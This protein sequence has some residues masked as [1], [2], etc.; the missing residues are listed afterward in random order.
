M[1]SIDNISVGRCDMSNVGS[2]FIVDDDES[3]LLSVKAVLSQFGYQPHCF[4]SADA[5]LAQATLDAP[6][7]VITDL[8]MPGLN[9]LQLQERLA[10]ANSMLSVIVLTGVAD[11]PTAVKV[12]RN[13][14]AMLLEKP[15]ASRDLLVSV[16]QGIEASTK[17]WRSWQVEQ[18]VRARLESLTEDEHAVMKLMLSGAPNKSIA[19]TMDL[20]MRTVDRRRQAIFSKMGVNTVA[21]L[22]MK[23]SAGNTGYF[24]QPG[25]P[26]AE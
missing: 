4:T 24:L 10:A 17:R 21:E 8:Q 3:V 7:C 6:G 9:G 19:A 25:F 13:G 5:F 12:M 23:L 26:F 22:A 2:V 18:D 1:G 14:A 11:V 20:G 15:Y 16:Q